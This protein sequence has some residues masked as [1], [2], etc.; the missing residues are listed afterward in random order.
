LCGSNHPPPIQLPVQLQRV[1]PVARVSV[2]AGIGLPGQPDL[3]PEDGVK[4]DGDEDAD[5]LHRHQQPAEPVD[6]VHVALEGV[7]PEDG[8]GVDEQ[9]EDQ[10][11]TDGDDAG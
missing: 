11:H 2:S 6:A 9:V 10:E 8:R 5:E 1:A 3:N 7:R 4:C